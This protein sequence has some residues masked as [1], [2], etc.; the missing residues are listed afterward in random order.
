MRCV[1]T[2]EG[3]VSWQ[4]MVGQTKG[5]DV[6]DWSIL[7]PYPVSLK[8]VTPAKEAANALQGHPSL[9]HTLTAPSTQ[10]KNNPCFLQAVKIDVTQY[11]FIVILCVVHD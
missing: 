9:S 2:H 8:P 1:L 10:A 7:P 4:Q 3:Q 5:I 6:Q 11:W